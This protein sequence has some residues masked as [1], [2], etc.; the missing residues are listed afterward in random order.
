MKLEKWMEKN[1]K[2]TVDIAYEIK[3]A[4]STVYK[5]LSGAFRPSRVFMERIH[6]LTKGR[7]TKDDFQGEK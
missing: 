2:T 3:T 5:W 6:D 7:V 1:N 4:R